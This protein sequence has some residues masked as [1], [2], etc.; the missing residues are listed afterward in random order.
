MNGKYLYGIIKTRENIPL[1]ISADHRACEIQTVTSGGLGCV[2][3]DYSGEDFHSL[4][5]QETIQ[6]LLAHQLVVEQVMK[7]QAVLPVKFGTIFAGNEEVRT[8]LNQGSRQFSETLEWVEDK[9]EVEVAATWNV[10]KILREIANEG[11]IQRLKAEIAAQPN[12]T[13]FDNRIYLGKLV[14]A[15]M[16]R[17]RDHYRQQMI[18][19]LAPLA[20]DLQNN[21]LVSDELVMNVGFLI[22]K[23]DQPEFD[24]HINHLNDLLQN[25]IDFKVI[26]PLPPYSFATVEITKPD[27]QKIE[28]ARQLLNLDRTVSEAEVKRA[29]RR[30]AARMH[31]D[32][33]PSGSAG[34]RDFAKLSKLSGLLISYSRQA[35]SESPF[36][37]QI[38]RVSIQE[39][40]HLNIGE[41][42]AV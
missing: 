38:Q 33:N 12:N 20:I 17:R 11:E 40:E 34:N 31:P 28:E 35:Q 21:V 22:N 18:D 14:K 10:N 23:A 36:S 15:S 8:L 30:T 3:A 1:T 37:I 25:E 32:R 39:G 7:R 42:Q 24:S 19:Y 16:D 9:V 13:P 5:K 4:S 6:Q 29:Y 27:M 2:L 41:A 26:G